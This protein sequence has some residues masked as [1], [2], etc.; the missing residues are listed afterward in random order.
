MPSFTRT[1]LFFTLALS[2]A[3]A[4]SGAKEPRLEND[5]FAFALPDL[6]GQIVSSSDARFE[7]KVLFV[8][9]WGTWCPPCLSEVPAFIDLQ[10]RY[11]DDGLVIVAIAFEKVTPASARVEHLRK[12][13]RDRDVNYLVLDGGATDEF[14]DALPMVKDVQGLPIEI[15]VDRSGAVVECRNGYGYRKKWARKLEKTLEELLAQER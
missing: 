1:A 6:N 8:T 4:T 14:S 15:I 11:G 3:A 7:G 2:A 5:R 12:F 10:R 13:A 9:I